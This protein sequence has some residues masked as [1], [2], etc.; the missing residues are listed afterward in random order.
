MQWLLYWFQRQI[1][2]KFGDWKQN[3]FQ[4]WQ[5]MWRPE[6]SILGV[7]LISSLEAINHSFI[8]IQVKVTDQ[9]KKRKKKRSAER[10]GAERYR[11][12]RRPRARE[13]GG[14][15]ENAVVNTN[16]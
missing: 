2:Y 7:D 4:Q 14:E 1:N 5:E 11:P 15:M 12:R 3:E 13:K 6:P 10:G 8:Q 9:Y 16:D